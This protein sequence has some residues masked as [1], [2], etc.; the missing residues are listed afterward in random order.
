MR[1]PD[2]DKVYPQYALEK[3]SHC[4]ED[5]RQFVDWLR[6]N[7]LRMLRDRI[8]KERN[9]EF[10]HGHEE[11]CLETEVEYLTNICIV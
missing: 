9:C 2:D 1:V 11:E 8:C 6:M 7:L 10:N 4:I 3:A 5:D